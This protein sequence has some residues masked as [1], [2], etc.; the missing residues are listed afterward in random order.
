[1]ARVALIQEDAHPELADL[2]AGLR[3]GRAGRL[4][5]IYKLLL[6]SPPLASSWFGHVNAVR[7]QTE[8]DGQ[9]R[10]IAIIRVGILNEVEYVVKAHAGAY[11][12]EEGLT[13]EQCDA[14]A[15]WQGSSLFDGRQ[16]AVLALTDAMTRDIQVA[17]EVFE[18]LKTHF[19]ER[20]IV[21]LVVLIGT[22]NMH[23]RVLA[24]LEIDS[25]P[26]PAKS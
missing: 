2:V 13:A 20:Q 21:E 24:A 1:M 8:L 9:T 22:Y 25:E 6:H 4:L 14:L 12:L 26:A 18:A 11:A 19:N 23:T 15:D 10:E 5:N 16:R 3:G 17:D 7:W